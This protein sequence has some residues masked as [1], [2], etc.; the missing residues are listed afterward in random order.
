MEKGAVWGTGEVDEH[1]GTSQVCT[2]GGDRDKLDVM[3]EELQ[4]LR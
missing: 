3:I 2:C 1:A 4:Y